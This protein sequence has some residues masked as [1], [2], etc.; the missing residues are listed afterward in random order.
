MATTF[1]E[2]ILKEVP[3]VP[4]WQDIDPSK[5]QLDTLTGNAATTD[6]VCALSPDHAK[7]AAAIAK[8]G[9]APRAPYRFRRI[10]G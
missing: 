7:V 9:S 2:D 4:T 8:D 1:F 3:K 6:P 10:G 5:I